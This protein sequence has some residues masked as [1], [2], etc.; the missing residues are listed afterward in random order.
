VLN[1]KPSPDCSN[2][3]QC[4]ANQVCQGGYCLYTCETS[5]Q[6][7]DIDARIPVCSQNVCRSAAEANPA[8]TTAA[9]CTGGKSCI[10]NLCQ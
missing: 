8:C 10:S 9:Q 1:T 5:A 3:S 4:G 7:E 2:D 6:C